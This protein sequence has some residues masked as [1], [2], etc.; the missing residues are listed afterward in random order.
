[1]TTAAGGAH[2]GLSD[3]AARRPA[4]ALR[5]YVRSYQ[6]YR[7]S[8]F[9]AGEHVGLPSDSITVILPFD[10]PLR[11]VRTAVPEQAP[12]TFDAMASGLGTAPVVMAHD[13]AEHGIQI[14]FTPAGARA[15]LGV[16]PAA[17]GQWMVP[18]VDLLGPDAAEITSE[19]ESASTWADRF[20]LLDRVLTRRLSRAPGGADRRLAAAWTMAT[21]PDGATVASVATAVGWST[22]HLEQRFHS[23]FGVTPRDAGRLARFA[24]SHALVRQADPPRL[25]DVAARCG[26]YDQAH[27]AREWRALAGSAPSVWRR[28]E[29]FAFVQDEGLAF[30]S[31]SLS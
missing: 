17:L 20:A 27:L 15:V 8:G 26:F 3:G 12:G 25:A 19:C 24:R 21:G 10:R 6:G 28:D 4:P 29:K 11:V 13:G 9:D 30:E 22:R 14:S 2:V 5:P 16:P 1:M 18:L 23:E 31:G 7:L